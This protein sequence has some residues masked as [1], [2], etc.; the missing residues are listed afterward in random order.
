M[1]Y[2]CAVLIAH[3]GYMYMHV[4]FPCTDGWIL[5]LCLC[6]HC[7]LSVFAHFHNALFTVALHLQMYM[8]TYLYRSIRLY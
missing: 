3:C 8:D 6:I 7:T 4:C 2:S 5:P 1:I